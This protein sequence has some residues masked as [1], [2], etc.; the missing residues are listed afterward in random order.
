[1]R[2]YLN[3]DRDE[4]LAALEPPDEANRQPVEPGGPT[5]REPRQYWRWRYRMAERMV[6][7]L[8]PEAY[9]VAAV[10][11]YGS[12]KNGTA[13]PGSDIDLLVHVRGDGCK[14]EKLEAWFEGWGQALTE[15]NYSRTGVMVPRLLDVTYLTDEEI[16]RGEGL[17]ARIDAPTDPA[18]RLE[19]A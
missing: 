8:D 3:A 18:R 2:V 15:M 14:R 17:A 7:A 1:M 13:G 9:G 5:L 10:Y 12:V 16:A 4:A 11:L 19:F 6:R